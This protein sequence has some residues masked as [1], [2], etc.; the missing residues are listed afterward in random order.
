ML[1]AKLVEITSLQVYV[2]DIELNEVVYTNRSIVHGLGYTSEDL[3]KFKDQILEQ[4]LHP[5]D[6]LNFPHRIEQLSQ[7]QDHEELVVEERYRKAT[8]EYGW[9]RNTRKVF[10]RNV[11]GTVKQVMGCVHEITD[12][13]NSQKK[14]QAT[15]DKF[16]AIFNSTSDFN[17]FVDK[18][19][20][21][22]TLNQAAILYTEKYAGV[23]LLPGDNLKLAMPPEMQQ[24]ALAAMQL[25]LTGEIVDSTK[26][27]N[28]V[29]GKNIWFR[30][31]FFP[32]YD[33][34]HQ[35]ITGVNINMRDVTKT[36]QSSIELEHQ[37]KQLK[38]IA[39][40]NSHEIRRPL[41]NIL[42]LIEMLSH[43]K[44]ELAED[45]I[46]LVDL[47]HQSSLELD[48]VVKR[49]VSTASKK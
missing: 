10:C 45:V 11:D 2:F 27:Y 43:Y 30:A 14:L 3:I 46:D 40:I 38:E 12:Q 26:Q 17:F 49:I 6:L 23:K 20:N 48:E 42:G 9:F 4:V 19:L 33:D 29:D 34:L 5:D 15:E 36:V 35:Q 22:L 16:R 39:R 28:S 1:F 13:I 44:N 7:L 18:D 24:D 8:G 32:V 31:K 41:A 25:A 21:I 47:L 37:N